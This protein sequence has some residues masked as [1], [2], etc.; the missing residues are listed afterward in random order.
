MTYTRRAQAFGPVELPVLAGAVPEDLAGTLYRNGPG[1]LVGVGHWFDGDGA[2]LAVH[3]ARGRAR[4]T[5]R[6]VETE[7][8]V[9]ETKT[10]RQV[11]GGYGMVPPGPYLN[12]FFHGIKNAANTAVL[13]VEGK[14]LALWEG[15]LPHA[16]DPI[17][18]ATL[19]PDRLGGLP[20]R[21]T[22]SAHPKRDPQTGAIYNFGVSY[23]PRAHLHLYRSD[24][25]GEVVQQGV[26]PLA[27]LPLIHDF[28][29]AGEYLIFCVPPVQLQLLPLL[30]RQQPFG[31]AFHWEPQRGTEVLIID[32]TTLNL[33]HRVTTDP[34]YQW[35]FGQ[36]YQDREGYVNF[37]VARYPDFQTNQFLKEVAAG[38]IKTPAAA[39]L[40]QVRL[41]P[42]TGQILTQEQILDRSCEFPHSD[43]IYPE[44]FTYLALHAAGVS[45]PLDLLGGIGRLDHHTGTLTEIPWRVGCYPTEPLVVGPW[46]LTVVY[47]RGLDQ[48]QVEV[49]RAEDL[50]AG[51]VCQLGLPSVVPPG[52]HGTWSN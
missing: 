45:A 8:Y 42:K 30:L 51:L 5:Y 33:V 24:S 4:A 46:L 28:V 43:P 22:Y 48:S 14:L 52:F 19:G 25:S 2:I 13:A 27:G 38:T 32:R 15:G 18:L 47:D 7:G 11:L 21:G 12:R 50:A 39:T 20:R 26:I 17:T 10:G 31:G 1:Q 3:F 49:Y 37:R 44:R 34:W 6:F 41:D 35:H 29:L 23:G 36:G 16:L 40:W 9:Q